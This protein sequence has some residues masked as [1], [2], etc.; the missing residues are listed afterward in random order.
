MPFA[1]NLR[2]ICVLFLFPCRTAMIWNSFG[3]E[4]YIWGGEN[5]VLTRL[6]AAQFAVILLGSLAGQRGAPHPGCAR[7]FWNQNNKT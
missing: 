3:N 4:F 7:P 2:W 1:D 5:A 6:A